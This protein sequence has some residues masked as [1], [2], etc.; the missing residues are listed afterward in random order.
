MPFCGGLES[1]F[2]NWLVGPADGH[3]ALAL[4]WTLPRWESQKI[5]EKCEIFAKRMGMDEWNV[6]ICSDTFGYVEI[7]QRT[8]S[9]RK[10]IL[11]KSFAFYWLLWRLSLLNLDAFLKCL[12][13]LEHWRFWGNT[14]WSSPWKFSCADWWIS[15]LPTMRHVT[16]HTWNRGEWRYMHLTSNLQPPPGFVVA[17]LPSE[18]W[19]GPCKMWQFWTPS[20]RHGYSSIFKD[21]ADWSTFDV[22]CHSLVKIL[23]TVIFYISHLKLGI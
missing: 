23:L 9:W 4:F 1:Q 19:C 14:S 20:Y 8:E 17:T 10:W 7:K 16:W 13:V 3:G 6:Q 18:I 5:F 12:G 21:E 2:L 15:P 22:A 11:Q